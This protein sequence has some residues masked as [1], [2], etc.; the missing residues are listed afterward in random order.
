MVWINIFVAQKF[1]INI[2]GP[3]G[4]LVI[5]FVDQIRW[6]TLIFEREND[7]DKKIPRMPFTTYAD[8]DCLTLSLFVCF[9]VLAPI[10]NCSLLARFL[11]CLPDRILRASLRV[12]VV[13]PVLARSLSLLR[14]SLCAPLGLLEEVGITALLYGC[15]FAQLSLF[16][17]VP[18]RLVFGDFFVEFFWLSL[19]FPSVGAEIGVNYVKFLLMWVLKIH[20]VEGESLRLMELVKVV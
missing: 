18:C 4:V 5:I 20:E 6:K 2:F 14:F 7:M 1:W 9:K 13:S 11:L 8:W 19:F 3:I 10:F 12:S 16:V 17:F 15:W